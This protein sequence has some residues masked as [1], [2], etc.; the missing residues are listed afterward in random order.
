MGNEITTKEINQIILNYWEELEPYC[1]AIYRSGSRADPIIENPHDHDYIFLAKPL[2]LTNLKR[3]IFKMRT[4]IKESLNIPLDLR[5]DYIHTNNNLRI[6]HFSYLDFFLELIAG[7]DICPKANILKEHRQEFIETIKF[8]AER[9]L[10]ISSVY[11]EQKRWY[12]I[13]RGVYILLNNSYE[14]TEEQKKEINILH[15]L[16][17]GWEEVRDKCIKLLENVK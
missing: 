2:Q 13:L 8:R 9:L 7:T 12:H 4:M 17:E 16:S 3:V 15:D 5:I 14:I 11:S 1:L 6:V 10:D